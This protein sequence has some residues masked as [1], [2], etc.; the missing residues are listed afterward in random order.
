M[1]E[2]RHVQ[3]Q[4]PTN[5]KAYP[6]WWNTEKMK[7]AILCFNSLRTGKHIQSWS[8]CWC[9]IPLDYLVSIPYERESISKADGWNPWKSSIS[10]SFNSLRTGKH[11]QR[12]FYKHKK[13][14]FS[15]E[16]FQFP[17][18]GKAYPKQEDK[19]GKRSDR[20]S[21]PYERESISK[22]PQRRNLYMVHGHSVSIPYERESISKVPANERTAWMAMSYVSIPYERESIS[23]VKWE[24]SFPHRHLHRFNSLRTGKHIQSI[25][26]YDI[27]GAEQTPC[28]NSLRTGKHIQSRCVILGC[29]TRFLFQFPT[30]GKAYPKGKKTLEKFADTDKVSIPYERESISKESQRWPVKNKKLFQFPTNGKAYPKSR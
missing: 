5:G 22:G 14:R 9:C 17:T 23:K 15:D 3:F 16:K 13:R 8:V 6:K 20:V 4:F 12:I 19:G 2:A 7:L 11:I 1:R 29:N 18:N 10:K 30:N 26:G 21:I 24:R 25:P 28:F 27:I